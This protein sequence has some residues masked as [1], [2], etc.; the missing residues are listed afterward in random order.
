MPAPTETARFLGVTP[1][2]P[3]AYFPRRSFDLWGAR[4]FILPASPDW[5][6]RDRGFAAFLDKTELIYPSADVLHERQSSEGGE[7]WR[8]R[9]DW[10]LRR[11]RAAYSRAWVVHDAQVRP[12]AS[13]RDT[14][15]R[16]MRTLLYMN[17]PIWSEQ[18][19]PVFNPRDAALIETDD[20]GSLKGYLS[21]TLVDPSESV[22]VVKYEPQR[23]ELKAA[24]VRPGLVILAD[25]FYP[26]W[27]LTIDGKTVPIFRANRVMRGAAVPAG[28][29][30][31]VYTYEPASFR[32]GVIISAGGLIVLLALAWL[33]P[34]SPPAQARLPR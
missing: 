32:A 30:T 33:F 21:K 16:R 19:R 6:S 5:A 13:D 23:V 4:Y 24:L 29:H 9:H 12:P 22:A 31:L 7:P 11:N 17:D 2:Q 8:V 27:R 1:G 18:G 25:T 10:Q 15:A 3:V 20:V 26:G 34:R 28:E 14:R